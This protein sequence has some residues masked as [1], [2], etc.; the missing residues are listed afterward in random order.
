MKKS[1]QR[2]PMINMSSDYEYI[3]A[4][5]YMTYIHTYMHAYMYTVDEEIRT[6]HAHDQ[7]VF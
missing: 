2:T 5:T 7:H 6:A 1:V 3:H 4:Y